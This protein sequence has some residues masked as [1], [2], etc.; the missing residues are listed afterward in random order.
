MSKVDTHRSS[1]GQARGMD[2]LFTPRS[3]AVVG[4][5]SNPAAIGGQPIKHLRDRNFAGALYPINPKYEEI[6]GLKCY[7]DLQ[8]LPEAPDLIVVAVAA[9]MVI[10]VIRQAGARGVPFAIVFSS[11]FAET[12]AD[13]EQAQVALREAAA[14]AGVTV[15]G[16]NCQGLMNVADSIPVGFGEPYGLEYRR[17][18]VSLSSQSGAFGNSL[19]MGLDDEGVGMRHYVSTG[20]EA[21]TTSLDCIEHFLCDPE[22]HV[23]AGY[24][25]G[26]RDAHRLRALGDLALKNETPLVFWKVGNTDAGAKAASSHTANLA[27]AFTYYEAAFRQYGIVGV[28]DVGDMA[29]CVRALLTRRWP[30]GSGIAVVSVSGGAGI[31]MADRCS[32]MGIEIVQL[33][34]ATIEQLRPLLPS[35]ASL[36]NPVDVTAGALADP[37]SFAN[38]LRVVV[39][40]PGVDMLGLCLAALAGK[41]AMTIATVI[42]EVSRETDVPIMVAWNPAKGRAVDAERTLEEA[43]IPRY[44]SPVRCARGFGALKH[45]G[46]ARQRRLGRVGTGDWVAPVTMPDDAAAQALN[47]FDSKSFLARHGLPVTLE[48][49]VN[50]ADEAVAAAGEIGYPVVMKIL[51][52]DIPHKSD[53]GGVRVGVATADAVRDTYEELAE[54]PARIGGNVRFDGVLVQEMVHGGT[55]VILGAVNDPSFGPVVMF[56]AGGVYAEVFEDV[57][58]RL[59][60]LS[61]E[62]AE[63]MVAETRISRILA[64]ARGRPK[65]DV[66]ALVDAIVQLSELAVAESGSFTEIDINPLL[67]LPEGHGARVVDAYVKRVRIPR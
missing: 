15:I 5:S 52:S 41:V 63:E 58:F 67:V 24:V 45:F 18:A 9:H 25:E 65:G 42:A 62:D 39:K 12:G 4:A 28:N 1:P 10:D 38:A 54:L 51:S 11:G 30:T 57:A 59:A 27:G 46:A 31:A 49:V 3:V 37:E 19:V 36:S 56:G 13:G 60:P 33:Q 50:S 7:P 35:F 20:N 44:S 8:A 6:A 2:R 22:N 48:S 43:G 17:G 40:D 53:A 23:V 14:A 64:G 34:P 29:D 26:F 47:E 16:P 61:R 66:A 32:E 55:E 21:M